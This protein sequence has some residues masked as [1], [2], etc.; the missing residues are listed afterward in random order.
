MPIYMDRH[1]IPEAITAEH[2]AE[3]HR[4]DLKIEHLFGCK[5][6]TY[7][8]DEKRRTAFCLINAPNKQA[9]QD[10]H[11][12]AHG[13]VPHRIIEVD[14][15]IVESFLGR[16]EDPEKSQKTEL[17]IINDPAFRTIMV[18]ELRRVSFLVGDA[19]PYQN[20]ILKYK[21]S[22]LSSIE[23]FLGRIVKQKSDYFLLSF[24]SV[25]NAVLCA[26]EI[27][28]H[29]NSTSNNLSYTGIQLSIG[30][31]AGVPVTEKESIFEDTIIMAERFC[32]IIHGKIV[33]SHEV[34][35]L[36]ES[37]NFNVKL[38]Q[39]NL[40][41]LSIGEEKFINLIMDY[42]EKEW[43]NTS[44]NSDDF[45]KNLGY[46]KSQLYRKMIALTSKSPN[47]F[48][49]DY[50]LKNALQLLKKNAKNISET[51]FTTGFNSP[52]YFSKC[53]LDNF[54]ILP[55]KYVQNYTV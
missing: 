23:K 20:Q 22:I 41:T 18:I 14:G 7:W 43:T 31:H 46:S 35:Q 17:N 39:N 13:D 27:H 30:L 40:K 19:Q 15:T 1:D 45:S 44:F 55:S 6:M 54:G 26:Q 49:K 25:T 37:E 16:I 51:A 8:C 34:W 50:R 33:L 2:V 53:F 24:N 5:G 10:M 29:L 47:N 11:D 52:A 21:K 42:T 38:N 32:A 3:M 36:Y 28:S 9:I 48:I 4:E 12:H